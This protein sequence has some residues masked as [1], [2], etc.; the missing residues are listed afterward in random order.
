MS[1]HKKVNIA[2]YWE[3]LDQ[4]KRFS[5]LI[6]LIYIISL[7]IISLITYYILKQ[8]AI[9]NA[10]NTA[11]LYLRT[12]ESTR[13]FVAE[14]LRPVLQKELPG[15]FV[16][17]GMSR[18]Y[19]A[20]SI[21]R[22]VLKELP[23]HRFKNASLNPKNPINK[24]DDLETRIINEFRNNGETT[25]WRGLIADQGAHYYV[26]AQ[27][28]LPMQE[29]CLSCHGDPE[30]APKEMVALYGATGGFHMKVGER[31]DV[32]MAYIPVYV[33]LQ[34]ARRTVAVFIGLYTVF[35]WII[36]HLI[37]VRFDWFYEKIESDKNT[38]ESINREVMNLNHEMED[39]V[40][41]RTMGM[42]GLKVA[43]RI[44]NPVTVIG[45]LCHQ[46]ARKEIEGLPKDKL[47]A[48][49]SECTK[50]ESIVAD[51]DELVKSKRFLF[52]R[53]DLNEITSATLRLMEP[54][55]KDA[56][57]RLLVKLHDKQLM[58]NANRQ[59]IRITIQHIITNAVDASEP[60]GE[61]SIVTGERNDSILLTIRDTGKGMSSEELHRIF[62]P[63][64]STKG[65]TGMGLPLVRQILTEHMGEI[66][67]ES[68]LGVGT[69]VQ[70]IFPVR[71]KEE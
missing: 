33:A 39:I 19:V 29:S 61:I 56:G 47:Q 32:L 53:E 62:E 10:Y 57:L 69:T 59:L 6:I 13:Q 44:R 2:L 12:Y 21:S 43:D 25:E 37:H 23:G 3:K 48:I 40:A 30:A 9:N 35:F 50:L 52:K 1:T 20:R 5:I 34:D 41:E 27:A 66:T 38:I 51:F 7:P 46:L 36:F 63:F 65:K 17:Q 11:S 58:F 31:A 71:W 42:F 67:L 22:R 28:G 54:K 49:L 60:G 16:V 18:S 70:F 15:R 8:N 55:I 45:G 26:L 14:E 4:K 68:E 64:Y 24:A